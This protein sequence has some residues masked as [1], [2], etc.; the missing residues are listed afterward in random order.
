[1][2]PTAEISIRLKNNNVI[3]V[4]NKV[5]DTKPALFYINETAP[6]DWPVP[7]EVPTQIKLWRNYAS[8]FVKGV[9]GLSG[10]G[11]IVMFLSQLFTKDQLSSREQPEMMRL[12]PS[13]IGCHSTK[14]SHWHLHS[15][16]MYT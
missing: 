13:S 5:T 10:F 9:V 16:S 1:M 14:E 15:V 2:D 12:E 11:V 7:A 3:R 4:V 8:P 6:M